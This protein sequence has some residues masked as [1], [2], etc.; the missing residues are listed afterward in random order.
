MS[1]AAPPSA[2][3]PASALGIDPNDPLGYEAYAKTLW[4][5]IDHA[6]NRDKDSGHLGE[7]PLVVGLFGEWGVGKTY[8]LD[9]I[10]DQ[11]KARSK[12]LA[13]LHR[14]DGGFDLLIPVYFQPWKYEHEEHLHVPL[15][16]HTLKALEAGVKAAQTF[17]DR[18]GQG[19][20]KPGD[21]IINA[22][23]KIVSLLKKAVTSTVA[24]VDPV[25]R[26]ALAAAQTLADD[27]AKPKAKKPTV[28]SALKYTS[29]GRYYFEIQ[30]VLKAITRPADDEGYLPNIVTLNKNFKVN[31]V[32][33]IDDLDRCLPEKA[34][35]V[36]ELIKTVF[37]VESFAF[38]LALDDEVIERGIG[39][40][41]KDYT[42]ENKKQQMPITGFEYLEKIV[43]LP[44]RLPALTREQAAAFAAIVEQRVEPDTEALRWFSRVDAKSDLG[45]GLR[46]SA[47]LL[48][49]AE[50]YLEASDQVGAAG[51]YKG[52]RAV[53][54][55]MVTSMRMAATYSAHL[56]LLLNSF[57]AFV[58]RKIVRAV[59]LW[60][61]LCRVAREREVAPVD[62]IG[63][64]WARAHMGIDSHKQVVNLDTRVIFALMLL[65]LFQP[66]LFRLMRRRTLAFPVLLRAFSDQADGLN[67]VEVS[68]VDIWSWASYRKGQTDP[69]KSKH[70]RPSSE[71]E[72][73]ALI[74]TLEKP[75]DAFQ[76]QQIRLRIAER[77]IEHFSAQRHVF[78]PLKLMKWLASQLEPTQVGAFPDVEVYFTVLSQHAASEVEA[79]RT[80]EASART[81][82]TSPDK[83]GNATLTQG[84]P[85][86]AVKEVDA[87]FDILVA[88][89][90]AGRAGIQTRF[91]LPSQ[92]V[93]DEPTTTALVKR[94]TDHVSASQSGPDQSDRAFDHSV[95]ALAAVAPWMRWDDGAKRIIAS[96]AGSSSDAADTDDAA[97]SAVGAEAAINALLAKAPNPKSRAAIGDLLERFPNGDP[98]FD[99]IRPYRLAAKFSGNSPADEPIPG[100]VRIPSGP[101][102]MGHE[103]EANE[104]GESDNPPREVNIKNDFYIARVLT[105]VG[106]YARFVDSGAYEVPTDNIWSVEGLKWLAQAGESSA[107]PPSSSDRASAKTR[108][109]TQTAF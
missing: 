105:T 55:D 20:Q 44:F 24:V 59:E 13:E 88:T 83:F 63:L 84:P 68:D 26:G 10:R 92:R 30:K 103:T 35:Q 31:F 14:S 3:P 77:L 40:R 91:S 12:A 18:V 93:F 8:L 57:D 19:A 53:S 66:E 97:G 106:Q 42:F 70:R 27:G 2:T 87:L 65:Q 6:L 5:R 89:D 76:A 98:R 16:L 95:G 45:R 80:S 107:T 101:F 104:K 85:P 48:E 67:I 90:T 50:A 47:R 51:A 58:P 60:H 28:A 109:N 15:L 36:L 7:D 73:L 11:A 56:D 33:F 72:A 94:F 75:E 21:A 22:L 43:H 108:K 9:K 38:V 100:F 96:L 99:A 78:N 1:A 62:R 54:A 39:H 102:K 34:V 79:I 74:A 29:D 52:P 64:V 49:D 37:N 25:T 69:E 46:G 61:Q 17:W 86:F 81:N 32:V 4:T 23:P 82:A 71:A 41:Y